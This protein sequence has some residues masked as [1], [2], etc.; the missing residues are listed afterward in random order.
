MLFFILKIKREKLDQIVKKK[1]QIHDQE[2]LR[3]DF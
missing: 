2:N 1:N 3:A